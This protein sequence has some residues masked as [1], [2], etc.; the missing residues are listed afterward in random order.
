VRAFIEDELLTDS[1]YRESIAE[2]RVKKG[3]VAAGAPAEAVATLIDRRLL[4]VEERLDVRRVELTH[5]VLCGV[6]RASRDVRQARE[7]KTAA[8]RLLAETQ[9]KEAAG[10]GA[11]HRARMV[12]ARNTPPLSKTASGIGRPSTTRAPEAAAAS[13]WRR[14]NVLM[15]RGMA[16]SRA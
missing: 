6:V 14:R 10:R 4:R 12:A 13:T 8:E 1:G 7:A 3:F 15:W 16:G 5:D 2:E 9:A 11:L